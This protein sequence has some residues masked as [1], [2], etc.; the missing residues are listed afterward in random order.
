MKSPLKSSLASALII[1][2]IISQSVLP[3][4]AQIAYPTTPSGETERGVIGD[5][6]YQLKQQA[7]PNTANGV[8]EIGTLNETKV[9]IGTD[10]P[11]TQLELSTTG[12]ELAAIMF[13]NNGTD[14]G[15]VGDA[16][17]GNDDLYFA[18][19]DNNSL[20]FATHT[21]A[22]TETDLIITGEGNVGIGT[23]TP[24]VNLENAGRYFHG[25]WADSHAVR[26][27]TY[28]RS[29]PDI[30]I[31]K[32]AATDEDVRLDITN[33]AS[34][35]LTS[36][37]ANNDIGSG[38]SLLN[39]GSNR[40]GTRWGLPISNT[41]E[42]ISY[43]DIADSVIEPLVLGTRRNDP[44]LI[45]TNNL[46]RVRVDETG[47]IGIGTSTPSG[48]VQI[49]DQTDDA[50]VLYVGGNANGTVVDENGI[51]LTAYN[52]GNNYIDFKTSSSG[53]KTF[54]RT[55]SGTESGASRI[56]FTVDGT[57][58]DI[59][60]GTTTPIYKLDV[61]GNTRIQ[62]AVN[63]A[64]KANSQNIVRIGDPI[65]GKSDT[66]YPINLFGSAQPTWGSAYLGID[67]PNGRFL[68]YPHSA[69]SGNFDHFEITLETDGKMTTNG[70]LGVGTNSPNS[71]LS[72]VGLPS[73]TTDAAVTG[74]LAGAVCITDTGDMY[75]DT[76]G[77]CAN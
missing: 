26:F 75:I 1:T 45:G 61:D 9:G 43:G 53:G 51:G 37:T 6:V 57:N 32:S 39:N 65:G 64:S 73:G 10:N 55:G 19:Y 52:D 58:G 66:T 25:D 72:V 76:D 74:N 5:Y 63:L 17:N 3:A 44:V 18:T 47:R 29:R 67:S 20:R 4:S 31:T 70:N 42:I 41:K 38:V 71:K 60:I 11:F 33:M 35:N 30:E 13:D 40:A 7:Y 34:G 50:T 14:I 22:S 68:I 21:L 28:P 2:G 62:G 69:V 59:G 27:P 15:Y 56:A 46:E 49:Q 16:S 48:N 24:N 23:T 77:T 54:I 36:F 12:T 8:L